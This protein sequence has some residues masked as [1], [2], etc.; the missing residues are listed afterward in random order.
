MSSIVNILLRVVAVVVLSVDAEAI[1]VYSSTEWF[2]VRL[3]G[4]QIH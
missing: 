4:E 3:F 2:L 1:N